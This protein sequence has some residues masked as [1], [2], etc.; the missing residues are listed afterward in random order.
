MVSSSISASALQDI[1]VGVGCGFDEKSVM[2]PHHQLA[3]LHLE[4]HSQDVGN[5]RQGIMLLLF[6]FIS[7]W[8]SGSRMFGYSF[9]V[10]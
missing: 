8:K 2:V 1:L 5:E 3:P 9:S 7:M 6:S 10:A 4:V